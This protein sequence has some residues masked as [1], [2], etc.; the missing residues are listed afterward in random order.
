L[1]HPGHGIA[2]WLG[3]TRLGLVVRTVV[4]AGARTGTDRWLPPA[5]CRAIV[6]QGMRSSLWLTAV[7]GVQIFLDHPQWE[8]MVTLGGEHIAQPFDIGFR[9]LAVA[10]SRTPWLHQPFGLQEP[11][12]GNGDVRELG[13]QLGEH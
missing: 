12:L 13:A 1:G 5:P 8:V 4:R 11:D 10:S 6:G 7:P 2:T 9:E 3:I